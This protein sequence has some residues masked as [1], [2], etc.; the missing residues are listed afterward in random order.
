MGAATAAA[1]VEQHLA[2]IAQ[3]TTGKAAAGVRR[4]GLH[5]AL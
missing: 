3:T 5:A 2:V 1:K 4:A